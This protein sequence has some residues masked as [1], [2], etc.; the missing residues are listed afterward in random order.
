[1][2]AVR[3]RPDLR[4]GHGSPPFGISD[5]TSRLHCRAGNQAN[6]YWPPT[7]RLALGRPAERAIV[8]PAGMQSR[9]RAHASEWWL[10]L[11]G[12]QQIRGLVRIL[13]QTVPG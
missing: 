5:S 6:S 11:H 3:V 7:R 9:F 13:A 1:M 2:T 4:L 10:E 8:G 12:W